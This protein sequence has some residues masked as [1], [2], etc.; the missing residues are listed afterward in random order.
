VGQ[1]AAGEG[2]DRQ[3]NSEGRRTEPQDVLNPGPFN[4]LLYNRNDKGCLN[5]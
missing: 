4:K 5:D 3:G 1:D 2:K